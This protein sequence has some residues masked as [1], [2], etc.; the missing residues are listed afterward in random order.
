MVLSILQYS[1]Q[2]S[3]SVRGPSVNG[4]NPWSPRT[5]CTSFSV[6]GRSVKGSDCGLPAYFPLDL[7]YGEVSPGVNPRSPSMVYTRFSV[8]ERSVKGSNSGLSAYFL[9]GLVHGGGQ[10]RDETA[11]SQHVSH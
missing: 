2:C 1:T 4:V 10:S 3:I 11:V 8:R 5:F 7:V 6:R 9:L